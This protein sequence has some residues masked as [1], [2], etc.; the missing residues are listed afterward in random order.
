VSFAKKPDRAVAKPRMRSRRGPPFALARTVL[1]G[2]IAIAGAAWALVRHYAYTP[3][4]L[5]V[6]V[7]PASA[8]TYDADAGEIPVPEL[9]EPGGGSGDRKAR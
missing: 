6:P 4:P 2:L 7:A 9:L 1:L 5:R 8:P 3:P